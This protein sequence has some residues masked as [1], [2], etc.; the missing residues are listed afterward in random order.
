M[1][2]LTDYIEEGYVLAVTEQQ[3]RSL[4]HRQWLHGAAFPPVLAIFLWTR[5]TTL[6]LFQMPLLSL[7]HRQPHLYP[8]ERAIASLAKAVL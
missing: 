1:L 5:Q 4:R 3:E 7:C 8:S 6:T 2:T